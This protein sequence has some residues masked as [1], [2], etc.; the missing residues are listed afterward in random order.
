MM[1]RLILAGSV[2]ADRIHDELSAEDTNGGERGVF[3]PSN[4]GCNTHGKLLLYM[5]PHSEM[6][7]FCIPLSIF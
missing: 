7:K 3:L 1:F 2:G 5:L 6:G 4:F